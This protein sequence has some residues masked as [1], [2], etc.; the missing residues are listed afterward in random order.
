ME[1]LG[2]AVRYPRLARRVEAVLIDTLILGIA[3]FASAEFVSST[4]IHVA[5]KIAIV[6]FFPL[7]LEPG[8]V[9][10]TGAT[11]GH[12]LRG[13]RVVREEIGGNLSFLRSTARFLAKAFLGL[14]SLVFILLTR[15]HQ[16]L[17]DL[18]VGSLVIIH[19]QSAIPE[20]ETQT[21][22]VGEEGGFIYP[23]KLRRVFVG[24]LYAVVVEIFVG[25]VILVLTSRD[26]F[27]HDLCSGPEHAIQLAMG[28]VGFA[29][30]L[31]AFVLGWRGR[32]WGC[33]RTKAA[34]KTKPAE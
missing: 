18:V 28:A 15:R 19:G 3:F 11:I 2:A 34:E 27:E 14:P 8:L 4:N 21:E 31:T 10:F 22:R 6:A 16:A 17:H 25:F 33:R 30:I 23:S 29:L 26:C 13:L 5:L 1:R 24:I 32:L 9:S 20:E 7:A 12:R